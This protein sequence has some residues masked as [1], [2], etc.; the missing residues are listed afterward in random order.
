[1]G[2]RG[3]DRDTPCQ[4]ISRFCNSGTVGYGEVADFPPSAGRSLRFERVVHPDTAFAQST[5][6]VNFP[7]PEAVNLK[8]QTLNTKP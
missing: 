5:A 8:P 1:M 3:E 7:G 2:V 6:V 4:N